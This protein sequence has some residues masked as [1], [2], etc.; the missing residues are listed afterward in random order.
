MAMKKYLWRGYTYKIAD[1][2]LP[3]YP[4]AVPVEA[5]KPKAKPEPKAKAEEP[6]TKAKEAP[7]NKKRTD[8]KN[9]SKG[10]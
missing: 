3:K 2:D 4:G 10:A 7:K 5:P 1:E 9:K 6:K 8:V